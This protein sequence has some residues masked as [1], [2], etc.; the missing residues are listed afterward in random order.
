MSYSVIE[1]LGKLWN[2]F[3]ENARPVFSE[4]SI[5]L[6]DIKKL[7]IAE[8]VI[9]ISTHEI[10]PH[11]ECVHQF[12]EQLINLKNQHSDDVGVNKCYENWAALVRL[13]NQHPLKVQHHQR[14]DGEV[15][16]RYVLKLIE[17]NPCRFKAVEKL[18]HG[19]ANALNE[20]VEAMD[21]I[22][23]LAF[24]GAMTNLP[25]VKNRL[26]T[27]LLGMDEVV[28]L[29]AKDQENKT[30]GHCW[31]VKL[32]AVSVGDNKKANVFY[33]MMLARDPEFYDPTFKVGEQL[34]KN[35]VEVVKTMSDCD[36]VG[37]QHMVSHKFHTS[38]IEDEQEENETIAYDGDKFNAKVT[39]EYKG[40]NHAFTRQHFIKMNDKDLPVPSAQ[41]VRSAFGKVCKR[42]VN[43]N[44]DL[45]RCGVGLVG[46]SIGLMMNHSLLNHPI[47][48]RISEKVSPDQKKSD[49][50][51][52]QA[53]I[54]SDIW[55]QKSNTLFW[56][57]HVPATVKN[58]QQYVEDYGMNFN[59]VKAHVVQS[60]KDMTR[61]KLTSL[62]CDA[63][64]T[65]DSPTG[66]LNELLQQSG[67]PKA[68]VSMISESRRPD[69]SQVAAISEQG[70]TH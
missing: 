57:D 35:M 50:N 42:A 38:I 37:Y 28:C 31:G 53:L 2:Q 67:T 49:A 1:T 6:D 65:A 9:D 41:A 4:S 60:G 47:D 25:V 24:G 69:R 46:R 17:G 66:V 15:D 34:R 16:F 40:D 39:V 22:E 56:R 68:W 5:N 33:V 19:D 20:P 62:V 45:V 26:L 61:S 18:N 52:L 48:E 30:I 7:M 8:S 32:N 14:Q 64:R 63:I 58:L 23:R 51:T 36:F 54:L 55:T 43:S 44:L 21:R 12:T 59:N 3:E 13:R 10:F 27:G 70:V 29:V 11:L